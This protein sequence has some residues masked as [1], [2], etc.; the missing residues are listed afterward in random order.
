VSNAE[1]QKTEPIAAATPKQRLLAAE[2]AGYGKALKKRQLE[3]IAIGGA[4]GT[5]LF[6]GAGGRL[7]IAGPFL[8]VLYAIAG[9]FAFMVVRALGELVV[10]RPTSGSF[11]SYAREFIGEKGAYVAG[12]MYF[13]VWATGGIADVTA[14]AIYTHYWDA[15]AGIP[16]WVIA[17]VALVIVLSINLVSVRYFGELE[18]W[19]AMIKVAALVLFLMIGTYVLGSRQT[20]DGNVTGPQLIADNGGM[21][22]HGLLAAILVVP[23]VVFAYAALEMVSIAAGETPEPRKI[24]PKATNAIVWRI[25]IFYVGSVA[26]LAMLLPWSSYSAT[27]S[28]FVTF[29]SSIG[30]SGAGGIMNFVVL[31]AALSSVNSG[32]YAT[33]RILRSMSVA[34][35]APKFTGH[36]NKRHVPHGGILLTAAFYLLGIALN[37]WIPADAFNVVLNFSALGILTTWAFIMVSHLV[38][39]RRAKRGLASR[40]GYRLPGSPA[41]DIVTLVFLLTVYVLMWFDGLTG[42]VTVLAVVPIGLALWGG[43]YAVRGRVGRV[44]EQFASDSIAA[45]GDAPTAVPPQRSSG[46]Q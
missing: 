2:D 44:A 13:L 33:G 12:W 38:F 8:A 35:S 23:G 3:M 30:I 26:L 14:V 40:P 18:Y 10:H 32:L 20:V 9:F 43:W 17:L 24:V 36:M 46:E 29:L 21:L 16:Q 19:C 42:K 6:L 41:T 27:E 22:P 1:D 37:Y 7:N 5:G 11:V 28:P 4:I 15:F 34:G 25:G 31:T 45:T 39:V